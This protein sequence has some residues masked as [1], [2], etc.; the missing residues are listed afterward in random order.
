ML[1][2]AQRMYDV[3]HIV[4]AEGSHAR[5][6]ADRVR[7][8]WNKILGQHTI[9]LSDYK[10]LAETIISTIEVVEG[11][12]A[13]VVTAKFGGAVLDAVKHLPK[14]RTAKLLPA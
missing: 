10:K 6:H 3:F 12:D 1:A 7:S 13:K 9:W 5:S 2:D 8:S 11:R 14:S 4:I